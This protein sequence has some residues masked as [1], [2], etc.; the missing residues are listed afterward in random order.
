MTT[1]SIALRPKIRE[2]MKAAPSQRWSEEAL[3][4]VLQPR[5]PG[6]RAVD[7]LDALVW[8]LGKDYVVS[9]RNDE[10]ECDVWQ[11]TETGKKA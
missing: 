1:A 10:L 11:L 9:S 2:V 4:T 8:N 3:V 5:I 6:T 7:V